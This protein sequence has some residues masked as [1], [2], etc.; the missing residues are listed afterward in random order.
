MSNKIK[1]K[2]KDQKYTA[3]LE[4][5]EYKHFGITKGLASIYGD[6]ESDI[7]NIILSVA[8]DQTMPPLP[9]ND[10][11]IDKPDYWGWFD[12]KEQSFIHIYPKYFLL[13]MCF[14][15]GM[16]A[17]EERCYGKAYRLNIITT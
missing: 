12:N 6:K 4:D 9:Q 14:P 11:D 17:E 2:P 3:V 16:D 5:K 7:L 13:N 15:Y 1:T 8:D 10:P